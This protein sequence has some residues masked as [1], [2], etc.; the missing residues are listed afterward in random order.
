MMADLQR[1]VIFVKILVLYNVSGNTNNQKKC[2]LLFLFKTNPKEDVKRKYL[3][4][5]KPNTRITLPIPLFYI[6]C[7]LYYVFILISYLFKTNSKEDAKG[8]YI[9][10]R[11]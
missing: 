6:K 3:L 2:G 4:L 7:L 11:K 8:K 5:R 9:F 10:L 1:F